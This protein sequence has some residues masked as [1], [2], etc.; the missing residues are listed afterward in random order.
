[1]HTVYK[2]LLQLKNIHI[3][4]S[5]RDFTTCF[6]TSKKLFSNKINIGVLT[7]ATNQSILQLFTKCVHVPLHVHY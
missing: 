1:M 3:T 7:A 4:G 2:H 5:M 6:T